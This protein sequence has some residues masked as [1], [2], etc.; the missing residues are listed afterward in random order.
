MAVEQT[1]GGHA[2]ACVFVAD[3]AAWT[4]AF[5]A[6]TDASVEEDV[7][8]GVLGA[9]CVLTAASLT[10]AKAK[11]ADGTVTTL[12]V[13]LAALG[14]D[15]SDT[16]VGQAGTLVIAYTAHRL[17][18]VGLAGLKLIAAVVVQA[19]FA[20]LVV[21]AEQARSAVIRLIATQH[22]AIADTVF[23]FAEAG[24]VVA[25]TI[26]A[27]SGDAEVVAKAAVVIATAQ[28]AFAVVAVGVRGAVVIV[29]TASHA[30]AVF[31]DVTWAALIVGAATWQASAAITDGAQA[32]T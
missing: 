5:A 28:E 26:A 14:A 27:V 18:C 10:D 15:P 7:A 19:A 12:L 24:I 8:E 4:T 11:V 30:G 29:A 9:V 21:E 20:A 6:A 25:A 3:F 31:A 17:A 23:V 16:A 2:D 1:R 22:A 32:T 13:V